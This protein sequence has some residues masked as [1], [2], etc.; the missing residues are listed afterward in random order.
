MTKMIWRRG[1]SK[2][3]S[4]GVICLESWQVTSLQDGTGLQ[5]LFS[6]KK[7]TA[8]QSTCGPLA[9]SLLNFSA[10][11]KKTR[12]LF[13]IESRCFR[14]SHAFLSHQ[15]KNPRNSEKG[16][17]FRKMINLP[18]FLK[19][20]ALQM[21]TIV[22]LLLIKKHWNIWTHLERKSVSIW[23][24]NMLGHPQRPSIFLI[25]FY[26]LIHIFV[27]VFRRQLSIRYLTMCAAMLNNASET[28]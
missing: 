19:L 1:F 18:W 25:K 2:Q 15:L 6:W 23:H 7:T 27:S 24:K 4:R 20:S 26:N 8:H 16:F 13:W 5:R 14:E 28:R 17:H 22:A 12:Q 11:W 3:R 21:M 9:A 10:W